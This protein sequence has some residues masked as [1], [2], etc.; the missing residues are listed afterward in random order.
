MTA[1][2][3]HATVFVSVLGDELVRKGLLNALRGASG[4]LRGELGRR[5]TFNSVPEL[6]FKYD[7]SIERGAEMF[8]LLERVKREDAAKAAETAAAS[9][10]AE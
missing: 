9:P 4:V 1:D 10:E 2:Y 7:E 8:E 6:H 3:K 5:K